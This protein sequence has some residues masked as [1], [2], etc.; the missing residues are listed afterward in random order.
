MLTADEYAAQ[1]GLG[2]TK[3]VA[4]GEVTPQDLL[5]T[6]TAA[7]ARLNP[8]INAVC[9]TL[10]DAAAAIAAGPPSW[11]RRQSA[12]LRRCSGNS[13]R[14]MPV[15]ARWSGQGR[16]SPTAPSRRSSTAPVSQ[17]SPSRFTG[18]PTAFLSVCN[19]SA[20][21][22]KKRCCFNLR[23]SWKPRGPGPTAGRRYISRAEPD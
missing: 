17:R 13:T 4:D 11:S 15:S 12:V 8:V 7:I 18:R 22:A 19:W 9:R 10:P 6:V 14:I 20:V 3:L 1:D 16:F 5:E 23:R 2:L 21:S